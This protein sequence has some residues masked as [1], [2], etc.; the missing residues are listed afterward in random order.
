MQR[1]TK[2]SNNLTKNTPC[3]RISKFTSLKN[4]TLVISG[5]SR[6][7]GLAIAKK[8]AKDGAN[9]VILAKSDK[10]HPKLPGTIFTAAKEIELA[11]GQALPLKCDI[12]FE[13]QVKACIKKAIERFGGIDIV[14]NNASAISM[15][16]T[17]ETS[18]KRYDLMNQVNTR[19]TFLLTKT[20]LPYLKKSSYAHVITLSPPLFMKEKWFANHVAYSMSKYGMSMCVLGFAGEFR[21][22]NISVNAV[23][24][25]TMVAT[26]A[27]KYHLGGD[28]TIRRSR[29]DTIVADSVYVLLT[30]KAGTVTGGFFFDED[31]LRAQGETDFAKYKFDPKLKETDLIPDGFIN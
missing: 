11:G 12:R 14:I 17:E 22:W 23:W 25:K 26:S 21:E 15:S 30:S 9:I 3:P 5:A 2:I 24:P 7:I 31:I 4:K 6:G 27:I 28:E 1:I 8:A 10:P 16:N 19:G 18:M 20:C 29:K 13:D